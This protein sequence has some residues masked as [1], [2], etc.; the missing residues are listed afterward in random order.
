[1]TEPPHGPSVASSDP[2][3]VSGPN[4]W[5]TRSSQV[6]YETEHL[7]LRE[8]QVVQPDGAPGRYVYVELPWPVVAIVPIDEEQHVYLVRQW[9]YPWQRNSWEIP[10]GHGEPRETPLESAQRELAEEVGLE[11]TTWEPLGEGY[12]SAT[13]NARYHLYL[14]R[15]LSPLSRGLSRDGAE[16]DLIARRVPLAQAI[17]AAMNGHIEHGMSVVGLLRAARRLGV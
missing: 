4:P 14:A 3:S 1:M 9:R 15:G 8:D 5:Q 13:L 17:E 2:L 16:D 12:S 7:R 11:A 6:V 10:A